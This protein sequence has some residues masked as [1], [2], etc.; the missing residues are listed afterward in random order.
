MNDDGNTI[1]IY[2]RLWNLQKSIKDYHMTSASNQDYLFVCNEKLQQM[3]VDC[4]KR[5]LDENNKF[6]LINNP[7]TIKRSIKMEED[8]NLYTSSNA[9]HYVKQIISYFNEDQQTFE[10]VGIAL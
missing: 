5:M 10:L 6:D 8:A 1:N 2:D 7:E 9:L 3:N 4:I